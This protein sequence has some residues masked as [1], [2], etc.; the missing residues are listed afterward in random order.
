MTTARLL[1]KQG[2]PVPWEDVLDASWAQVETM[3]QPGAK[4]EVAAR[5]LLSWALR[6][7][8][9]A[10]FLLFAADERTR[11]AFADQVTRSL[12]GRKDGLLTKEAYGVDA[13]ELGARI[14]AW[15]GG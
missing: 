5:R 15:V 10:E 12:T 4:P 8:L 14:A 11:A 2:D 3:L 13:R 9:A 1:S 6:A 7:R